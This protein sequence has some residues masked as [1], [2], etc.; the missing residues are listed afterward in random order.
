MII[1]KADYKK[2]NVSEL[3]NLRMDEEKFYEMF[4]NALLLQT[5]NRVEMIFDADKLED[6]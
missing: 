1:L 5:C 6:I 4:D 3:E 2:Y